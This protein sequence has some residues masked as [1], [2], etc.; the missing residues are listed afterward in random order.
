MSKPEICSLFLELH[1]AG[2]DFEIIIYDTK[3]S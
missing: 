2:Y 3:Y 1:N